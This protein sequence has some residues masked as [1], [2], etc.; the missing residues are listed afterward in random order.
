MDS[1]SPSFQLQDSSSADIEFVPDF[2][3]HLHH[4]SPSQ[5][6]AFL[7]QHD[8]EQ[9]LLAQEIDTPSDNLS[10]QESHSCE[11]LC[12]DDP[13]FTHVTNLSLTLLPISSHNTTVKT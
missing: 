8:Y 1:S 11:K 2:E 12:Q 3:G 5:T 6:D 10:H 4:A 7:E 9:F 13:F